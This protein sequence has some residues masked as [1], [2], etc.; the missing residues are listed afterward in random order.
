MAAGVLRPSYMLTQLRYMGML[1]VV[2]ARQRGWAVR[3]TPTH[4]TTPK[5][6]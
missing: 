4:T 5:P 1:E 3:Y 6:P 2:R